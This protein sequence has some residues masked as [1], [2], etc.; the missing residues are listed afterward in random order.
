MLSGTRQSTLCFPAMDKR[1]E[2]YRSSNGDV[3]YLVR[4]AS[5]R[6]YVEHQPNQASGGTSSCVDVAT[7]LATGPEGPQHQSLIS[8]IGSLVDGDQ[9]PPSLVPKNS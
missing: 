9:V 3:W 2:L 1:K 7:F 4:T 6:A 8:L 5:G